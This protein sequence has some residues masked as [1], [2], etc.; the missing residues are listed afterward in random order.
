MIISLTKEYITVLSP[1]R[2]ITVLCPKI[3]ITIINI[4]RADYG[5]N[6]MSLMLFYVYSQN[7]TDFNGFMETLYFLAYSKNKRRWELWGHVSPS[8]II[9]MLIVKPWIYFFGM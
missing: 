3:Y 2:Y 9:K 6:I 4:N 8:P 7:P 1:K 5:V